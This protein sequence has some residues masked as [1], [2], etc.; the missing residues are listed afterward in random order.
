V[1][2][3]A[4]I[5]PTGSIAACKDSDAILLVSPAQHVRTTLSDMRAHIRPGTPIAICAKGV[6][7]NSGKFLTEVIEE[8]FPDAEPALLSGPSFARDVARGLPTAVTIAAREPFGSRLQATMFHAG[9]RPYATTDLIGVAL[10]GAAKN[11]YAIACGMVEGMGLG[12]SARAALLARSFAELMRL[13]LKLGAKAETLAGLSGLGDLTLTAMST[14]SRNYSL[15]L[16]LGQGSSLEEMLGS[17]KPLAE[18][19][20]TAEPLIERAHREGLEMPIA[21][22]VAELL[23]GKVAIEAV[24]LRLMTRPLKS[25]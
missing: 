1:P 7:K 15:G 22:A 6:E 25:E 2:L 17:G 10:G 9:F 3:P 19:A 5:K 18:G 21:E 20:Y 11:V 23:T 12:E 24:V 14:S 16:A 13:G 8:A 4:N